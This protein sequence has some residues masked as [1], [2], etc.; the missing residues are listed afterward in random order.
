MEALGDPVRKDA[1]IAAHVQVRER[2]LSVILNQVLQP[3]DKLPAEPEVAQ[4]LGVSRMTANR[5]IQSL[6]ADGFLSRTPGKGTFI[7]EPP[8]AKEGVQSRTRRIAI[9]AE[10]DAEH[11]VNDF[12]FGTLYWAVQS[13]LRAM[14]YASEIVTFRGLPIDRAK[15]FLGAISIAPNQNRIDDLLEFQRT[16]KAL[17]IVGADWHHFNL[18]QI[19]S[20]NVLGAALAVNHL[21]D[22]GHKNILFIG[23]EPDNSNTLD[24]ERG[25]RLALKARQIN[26]FDGWIWMERGAV[27]LEP[28][29]QERL[30][31]LLK[32][33]G[34]PTAIFAAGARLAVAVMRVLHQIGMA[35]PDDISV[36]TYD[37]PEFL[38]MVNPP[39]TTVSQPLK[40]MAEAACEY[41][42]SELLRRDPL[43]DTLVFDPDLVVR[44]STAP[45][46][47][48]SV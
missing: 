36:V 42:F 1:G 35:V 11:M 33:P 32:S 38:Q 44:G 25:F 28:A 15:E 24:R 8:E 6:V 37:D 46:P 45:V 4:L 16:G 2:I 3:G 23:G 17:V 22:L 21:I 13:Q 47:S 14:G 43:V 18:R 20:D 19:D 26:H 40:Q 9:I 12:Y 30:R 39:L 10:M 27:E 48:D 41:L 5:A 31:A 29:D 7:A 34:R